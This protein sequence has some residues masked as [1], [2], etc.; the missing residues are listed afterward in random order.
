MVVMYMVAGEVCLSSVSGK[1]FTMRQLR[2]Y[3]VCLEAA[4]NAALTRT[5]T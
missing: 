5:I 4:V 1:A 3:P 2:S